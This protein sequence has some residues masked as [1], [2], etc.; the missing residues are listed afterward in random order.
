M[1][2]S[3]KDEIDAVNAMA[4]SPGFDPGRLTKPQ[5]K[6][7]LDGVLIE[8]AD[9]RGANRQ[10]EEKTNQILND[11]VDVKAQLQISENN[12]KNTRE[13]LRIIAEWIK[14]MTE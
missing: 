14:G 1:S 7:Y 10:F 6:I 3:I 5:L 11:F 12:L 13:K 8:L 2:I 9:C 4:A